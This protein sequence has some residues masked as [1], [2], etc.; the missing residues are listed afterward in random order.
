MKARSPK[1]L[2]GRTLLPACVLAGVFALLATPSSAVTIT[3]FNADGFQEG[4]ND[5]TPRAPVG[6]NPGT[7]LGAQRLFVY[8][9]A[10]SVWGM[11]LDGSVPIV[12]KAS[13]DPLGGTSVSAVL[14][15]ARPTSVE[16]DF[17]DAPSVLTW[18]V[19]SLVH[20]LTGEDRNNLSTGACSA[21]D[22]VNGKCAEIYSYFNRDVDN[23]TVLGDVDFYYGIDGN[24][25]SDIDFLGV[26]L[27]EIG[28]GLGLIDLID[29]DTG[30]ISPNP[31][32]DTYCANLNCRDA[33]TLNLEDALFNPKNVAAMTG[34]QRTQAVEDQGNLVWAGPAVKAASGRLATGVKQGGAVLIYAPTTY[35][36]GSSVSHLDVSVS[37][38]ELMEPAATNPSPRDLTITLALLEDLGWETVHVPSCGDANDNDSISSADALLTL[39]AAVGSAE[40]EDYVCDV[41]LAGGVTSADALLI[42]KSAVGQNVTLKCPLA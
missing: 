32:A 14:G 23:Q 13:F 3:V 28:H 31:Q 2:R 35:Q 40:C 27:H 30:T 8:Q 38:N 33:Y 6:G 1:S 4:F 5:P 11:R 10:A 26:V 9:Y 18:Y 29:P 16:R 7:T 25:G 37:P 22:L 12:V 42:L 21:G 17:P 20:Q 15:S 24:S 36:P 34:N 41:N 19:A 39:K